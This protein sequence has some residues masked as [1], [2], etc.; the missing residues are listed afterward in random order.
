MSGKRSNNK[1]K[2]YERDI[3]KTLS[4]W[5]GVELVRTPLGAPEEIYHFP[6]AV[7]CKCDEDW[8]FDQ[9]MKGTGQWFS[10]LEQA[11]RQATTAERELGRLHIP[12]LVFSK[13]HY[14]NWVAVPVQ[15]GLRDSALANSAALRYMSITSTTGGL[16]YVVHSLERYLGLV[17]YERFVRDAKMYYSENG[18]GHS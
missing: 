11:Y 17:P 13:N 16:Q 1:G 5:S 18:P 12:M 6:L 9:I 10:W 3:A 4:S 2:R 15:Y 8:S 14:P 7:E